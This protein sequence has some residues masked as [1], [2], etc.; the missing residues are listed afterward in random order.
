MT[1][2]FYKQCATPNRV[3]KSGFLNDVGEM[4]GIIVK[5]TEKTLTPDFIINTNAMVYNANYFF[6]DFT[7]RYYYIT[8][9]DVTTGGR[10]IVHSRV[11]V[12]M[13]FRNEILSSTAWVEKSDNTTDETDDYNFL[14][15][16][17]PFRQDYKILGKSTS[18][19]IFHPW[20]VANPLNMVLLMK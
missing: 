1:L 9:F 18:D 3:D 6:C 10:I 8:G 17:Y 2:H 14:H 16:E 19:S 15:N 4:S 12:L 5:D 11:D 7:S 20:A 13:T